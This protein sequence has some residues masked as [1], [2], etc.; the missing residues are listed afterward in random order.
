VSPQLIHATLKFTN[1]GKY[2]AGEEARFIMS[3]SKPLAAVAA[4]FMI[5]SV[6]ALAQSGG[7]EPRSANPGVQKIVLEELA[8]INW[9]EKS[10]VAALREGVIQSMELQIGMPV[11][12]DGTIGIL[13]H[14][15]AELTVR[16]NKL[17]AD[18][19]APTEKAKAQKEVAASV[20]ARNIRLNERKAGMVS[21]EDVAKAE[22]ELKVADA[23]EH[24]AKENR[25]IAEADLKLAIQTLK[26]HTIVA[27]F[28]GV[29]IKR[30]KHPGESVRANEAVVELGNL[31]KLCADAFVPLEF[32]FRV[33]EGQIVEVQ[34]RL[35]QGK[36][37]PLPIEK[38]RF[39]GKI[40][41]VDPQ[42]QAVSETSVRIRAEFEN[43][44][45]ELRPGL[46]AQMT[47]FLNPEVAAAPEGIAPTD[48][49]RNQ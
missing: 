44:T 16:K 25:E 1:P 33:K 45:G 30:M 46:L 24:E 48:T 42:I 49:A 8:R 20:V 9:N 18:S 37:Q 35:M 15:M 7:D 11:K 43:P 22:G 23:Q 5:M 41:F 31:H 28:D 17:Q 14:E 34:P 39:R 3:V 36:G 32:A 13:H 10:A 6:A 4:S 26:E 21:A 12:K 19:I 38:K 29:I 27:P 47:I 40:T 2:P